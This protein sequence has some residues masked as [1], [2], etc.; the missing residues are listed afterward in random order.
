MRCALTSKVFFI[1][2][3]IFADE[4]SNAHGAVAYLNYLN[5]NQCFY[6]IL[7][8]RLAPVNL[9]GDKSLTVPNLEQTAGL[10]ACKLYKC[11]KDNFKLST[12]SKSFSLV[13]F[14]N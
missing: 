13:R 14:K 6:L 10:C 3:Y 5:S 11:I 7:K 8:E 2:L 1:N 4:S 12:Y 9:N